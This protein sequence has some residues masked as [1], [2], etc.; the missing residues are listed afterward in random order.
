MSAFK[1]LSKEI[2]FSNPLVLIKKPIAAILISRIE[3][4][5]K[6]L[7]MNQV[8]R[9]LFRWAIRR[10]I[11][12]AITYQDKIQLLWTHSTISN[13]YRYIEQT[14]STYNIKVRVAQTTK[15][16]YSSSHSGNIIIRAAI[17]R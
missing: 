16:Q 7:I 3:M 15:I 2:S 12:T 5:D 4:R 13:E 6:F 1:L 9:D 8:K 10:S 17:K 11:T 14:F